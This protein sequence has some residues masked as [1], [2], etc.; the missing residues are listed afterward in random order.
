MTSLKKRNEIQIFISDAVTSGVSLKAVCRILGLSVRTLQRW[1]KEGSEHVDKRTQTIHYPANKLTDVERQSVLNVANSEQFANL[2]PW[3][4]VAKLA[5]NNEY[6]ASE[7][8]FYRILKSKN[9]LAH[10]RSERPVTQ[11]NKPRALCAN[12]PN[13]VYSWDITYLPTRVRGQYFYLYLHLDVFSRKIVGFQVYENES[14][15]YA[16]DL[17]N[18]ICLRENIAPNQVVLHS[19]NGSVMRG[20]TFRSTMEALGVAPSFSRPSVSNDNPYSESAFRTL[21]YRPN[22]P[23]T[24]FD[25]LLEAR[26]WAQQIVY[27]YNEQHRHSK[28]SFVTPSQRHAGQDQAILAKRKAVYEAEKTKKPYRWTG[29]TRAWKYVHEVMLN[30]DKQVV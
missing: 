7:S 3:Q 21:K 24:P 17:L 29:E 19:D 2:S 22:Y 28:I 13:Q 27:W 15:E 14:G 6:I 18:D 30:P 4:I 16:S 9:Q 1:K 25:T 20:S 23:V 26:K 5:D 10:R 11:R 12:A 8:T